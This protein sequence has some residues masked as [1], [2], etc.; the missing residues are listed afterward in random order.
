LPDNRLLAQSLPGGSGGLIGIGGI[1][2][3]FLSFN[4]PLLGIFTKTLVNNILA[5][6]LFLMTLAFAWGFVSDIKD[7]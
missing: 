2:L 3:A 1:A 7:W 5:L 6:L 4:T